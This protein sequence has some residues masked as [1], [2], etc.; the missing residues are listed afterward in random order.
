[1]MKKRWP[2]LLVFLVVLF[3]GFVY[4]LNKI[5]IPFKLKGVIVA[6]L[7]GLTQAEVSLGAVEF[8]I[9]K[10][11]WLKDLRFYAGQSDLFKIK[12]CS[13]VIFYWPFLKKQLIIPFVKI[14]GAYLYLQRNADG[15]WNVEGFFKK[16]P[17]SGSETKFMFIIQRLVVNDSIVDFQ[18]RMIT[19]VLTKR[20][21]SLNAIV[22]LGLGERI[23]FRASAVGEG[24]DEVK[25]DLEG[26]YLLK[27]AR[28]EGKVSILRLSPK[29]FSAYW[30]KLGMALEAGWVDLK[31]NFRYD[32]G[33]LSL[34]NTLDFEA[35]RLA[36][37]NIRIVTDGQARVGFQHFLKNGRNAFEGEID[38]SNAKIT[39]WE[40]INEIDSLN[41][42]IGFDNDSVYS[43]NLSASVWGLSLGVRFKL[44]DFQHPRVN[45]Q[46]D[47]QTDLELLQ[48]L[49][50]NKF[51]FDLPFG[52]SG[53]SHLSCNLAF[54]LSLEGGVEIEGFADLKDAQL[55]SNKFPFTIDK[56][57]GRI[58][59][60]RDFL[61]WKGLT[62]SYG[63]TGYTTT[64]RLRHFK[65]PAV[66]LALSSSKLELDASL[67]WDKTMLS[68]SSCR[69]RYLNSTFS[70]SGN[71][72]FAD[73]K[74]I[75]LDAD[76]TGDIF[77]KDLREVLNKYKDTLDKIRPYGKINFKAKAQGPIND[78]A[79]FII[80]A[81]FSSP[82]ISIF[83]LRGEN[84]VGQYSQDSGIA[85]I[86]DL[87]LSFYGGKLDLQANANLASENL[88]F[89]AKTNLAGVRLELLK[90]DTNFRQG[91]LFGV[92]N[93]GLELNGYLK[94]A[95]SF[96][97][98]GRISVSEG[99]IWELNLFKGLGQLLFAKDLGRVVFNNAKCSFAIKDKAFSTHDL[100]MRS[101]FAE[102]TGEAKVGFD[103]TL[104]ASLDVKILDSMIPLTGTFKD[105][106]TAIVGEA[107][108]FGTILITGTLS[109]PKYK[110]TPSVVDMLKG[111]KDFFFGN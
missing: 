4:Y 70:L 40:F 67:L 24:D 27:E 23:N 9:F 54:W 33:I 94:D 12:E 111:V 100:F 1:M 32:E 25:I 13:F 68:L 77:L 89:R 22:S 74:N 36:K 7:Q 48:G 37:D 30:Q 64:G 108:R 56:I 42:K 93:A 92:L 97:G 11:F 82:E 3:I 15:A 44:Q 41:G 95:S 6:K 105:V 104:N 87:Q 49:A 107:T 8:N 79:K 28:S 96:T 29:D 80:Q 50:H 21:K 10:G 53:N 83:G 102:I 85:K 38:V 52:L 5:F 59:Y 43:D 61:D 60:G 98:A 16:A 31:T 14:K 69:G 58:E 110:F 45:L 81:D 86:S 39:G 63:G 18:D 101:N 88:A 103:S 78:L 90:Q 17:P 51:N 73:F 99:S 2:I 34:D 66:Q 62:F 26:N 109:E 72:D 84:L 75:S 47:T 106:T 35:L 46:V 71:F 76:A 20:L 65:Q 91:D 57:N 55:K 19:P